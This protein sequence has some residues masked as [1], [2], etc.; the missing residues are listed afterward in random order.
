ML[1]EEFKK[2]VEKFLSIEEIN[3]YENDFEPAYMAAETVSKEEFCKILKDTTTRRVIVALSNE[4][5]KLQSQ[6][7]CMAT[8]SQTTQKECDAL[9]DKNSSLRHHLARISAQVDRALA[10]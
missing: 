6:I 4:L 5:L 2:N 3:G 10:K 8:L 1:L 7:K 9:A